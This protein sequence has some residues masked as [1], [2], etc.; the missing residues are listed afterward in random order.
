MSEKDDSY[1]IEKYEITEQTE[2]C[3]QIDNMIAYYEQLLKLIEQQEQIKLEDSKVV[4]YLKPY[5]KSLIILYLEYFKAIKS[6]MVETKF[7][8][9]YDENFDITTYVNRN[10]SENNNQIQYKKRG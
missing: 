8:I 2:I 3:N 9:K 5:S 7:L 10:N 1:D 4:D 6:I